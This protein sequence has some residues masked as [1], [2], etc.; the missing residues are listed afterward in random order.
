[1]EGCCSGECQ[2]VVHLPEEKQR[3]V[4]QKVKQEKL[5]HSHRRPKLKMQK[6]S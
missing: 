2:E 1:M 4:R 3:E 5:F 6:N